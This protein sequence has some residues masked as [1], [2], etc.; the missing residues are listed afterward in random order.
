M[1][2][3]IS[4][5]THCYFLPALLVTVWPPDLRIRFIYNIL[6]WW[7]RIANHH[8]TLH[9]ST[10]WSEIWNCEH[11]ILK[12]VTSTKTASI[13]NKNLGHS[14]Q[15]NSMSNKSELMSFDSACRLYICVTET[16]LHW[17]A[18]ILVSS[19]WPGK[20]TSTGA[21]LAGGLEG[22]HQTP[23]ASFLISSL[24]D[25]QCQH[26]VCIEIRMAFY[27]LS[28]FSQSPSEGFSWTILVI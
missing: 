7:G 4:A 20:R 28:D 11:Q 15:L 10:L 2:G 16:F 3:K 12:S 1:L 25:V 26:I 24:D 8:Q 22:S 14:W 23:E 13:S 21:V 19:D 5:L 17:K 9:Q 27:T 6:T 18:H